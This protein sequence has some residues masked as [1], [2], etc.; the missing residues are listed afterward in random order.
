MEDKPKGLLEEL[1][2]PEETFKEHLRYQDI[3]VDLFYKGNAVIT[4]EDIPIL[5][6]YDLSKFD[7]IA[8]AL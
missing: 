5:K 1:G 7:L 4:P 2:L 3:C 8:M 6:K